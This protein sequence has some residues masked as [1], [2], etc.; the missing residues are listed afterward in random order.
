MVRKGFL[1]GRVE[2]PWCPVDKNSPCKVR[3]KGLIPGQEAKIPHVVGQLGPSTMTTELTQT[4]AHVLQLE[5][6]CAARKIPGATAKTQHS[7]INK[8]NKK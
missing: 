6:P 5:S 1:V 8:Q 2:L 7:Q 3:D 4:G